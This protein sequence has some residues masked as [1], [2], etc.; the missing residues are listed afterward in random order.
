METEEL[1]PR[2]KKGYLNEDFR[3]FHLTDKRGMEFEFHYH[4]FNKIIIFLTGAVIYRIEGKVYRLRPWDILFISRGQLHQAVVSPD[5]TYERIVI[6]VNSKFLAEHNT[7]CDLLNCFRQSAETGNNL[8]R[9]G[10]DDLDSLKP[11]IFL[12]E[13]AVKDTGYGAKLLQNSLFLQLMVYLNRLSLGYRLEAS[14]KDIEYDE[15]IGSILEYINRNLDMELSVDQL[16]ASFFISRYYLMHKFKEQTGYTVHQYILKK[17]L[18][19]AAQ[20]I[21]KGAQITDACVSCGFGDYSNFVRAFR[22][23]FGLSP[24]NY[25]KVFQNSE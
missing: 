7:D 21:K 16:S 8:R 20:L 17:R 22:K 1:D 23:E 11:T 18:I 25:Y 15:R 6:W 19:K 24:R 3:F 12:L 10:G 5:E 14:V 4:D 13:K 9:F 2:V